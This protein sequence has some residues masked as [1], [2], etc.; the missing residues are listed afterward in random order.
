MLQNGPS[1]TILQGLGSG[2]WLS[3][4]LDAGALGPQGSGGFRGHL[5][6]FY[7]Y[8]YLKDTSL[9]MARL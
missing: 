5:L 3:R 9:F 4:G 1:L 8:F 7:D 2:V 6:I